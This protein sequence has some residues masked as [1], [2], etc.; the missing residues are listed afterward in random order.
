MDRQGT[1]AQDEP[2]D[3]LLGGVGSG[4]LPFDADALQGLLAVLLAARERVV[5]SG[6]R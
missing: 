1:W 5:E 2:F 6:H 4:D 3:V